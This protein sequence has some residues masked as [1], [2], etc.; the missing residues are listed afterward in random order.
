MKSFPL[1]TA[2]L[3]ACGFVTSTSGVDWPAWGGNDLG[4]NMYSPAKGLPETF[5][6]GK[7]KPGSD[8]IDLKTTKNVKWAVKLGSQSYANPT[9]YKGK[10][11]VGTN[12]ETPRDPKHVGDR[13]ILMCFDEKTG[14]FLWQ[15]VVPRFSQSF[16]FPDLSFGT[17]SCQRNSPV[18]SSKHIRIERSPTCFGSRGVSLFVPTKTLPL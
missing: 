10:V 3:M 17:T 18:F 2:A 9:V 11:F 14:E 5:D 6:P 13:S 15:L 4:R 7:P 1:I 8:E 16:T 12:N